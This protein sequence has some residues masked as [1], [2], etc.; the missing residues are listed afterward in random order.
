MSRVI[1][2]KNDGRV[3]ICQIKFD[4]KEKVLVSVAGLPMPSIRVMTL[5]LG[6]IP[7]RTIW[8]YSVP[9]GEGNGYDKLV[10]LVSG[11][12]QREEKHPLDAAIKK[13]LPCRSCAEAIKVLR[14]ATAL[15]DAAACQ[16]SSQT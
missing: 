15:A 3:S 10:A 4:S 12:E 6:I 11:Q 9:A 13:L 5:L 16:P 1:G 8:E 7:Y 14:Q 2:Y